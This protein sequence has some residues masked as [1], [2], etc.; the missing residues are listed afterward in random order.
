ML[1][2][3]E[4]FV[5]KTQDYGETNKI[6]TVFSINAGK[7]AVIAKGAK[8]PKSR[9]AA[10]TQPFICAQF[11]V[12]PSKRLGSLQQGDILDSFRAIREDIVKTAYAAYIA[13]LTD[14]LLEN[15]EPDT[16][17][18]DQFKRTMQWIATESQAEVPVLMY[19][20]KLFQKAGFAPIVDHCARCGRT[21]QLTAFSVAEGGI[22][23][24]F[25][26]PHSSDAVVLPANLAKLFK[27][28]AK[29]GLERVG[30]VAVKP[31]NMR[32]MRQL[33]DTYYDQYGGLFLKSRKF[34]NQLDMFQ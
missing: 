20:L 23:C 24:R 26:F 22:L 32:L 4:G 15:H 25:C 8:K 10:L 30:T 5:I 16:Y 13:E 18:Y 2:K 19:E 1:E 3:V 29:I 27:L 31:E 9:M 14:K 7:F 34:L 28:F 17:I 21:D 6:V 33:M 12:Y 11:L